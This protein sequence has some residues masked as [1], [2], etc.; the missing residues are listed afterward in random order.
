MKFELR[1]KIIQQM[2][3]QI[4]SV[5]EMSRRIGCNQQTLYNYLAGG[6]MTARYISAVLNELGA[7]ISFPARKRR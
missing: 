6:N 1:K 3:K 4:I 2:A 7:K 5:P